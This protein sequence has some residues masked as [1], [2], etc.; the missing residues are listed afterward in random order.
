MRSEVGLSTVSRVKGFTRYARE[1]NVFDKGDSDLLRTCSK[2]RM[3]PTG[4]VVVSERTGVFQDLFHGC[5]GT[6]TEDCREKWVTVL[7]DN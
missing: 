5:R 1:G 4:R 2:P 6:W 7:S 3:E